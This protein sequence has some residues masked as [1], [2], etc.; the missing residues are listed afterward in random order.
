MCNRFAERHFIYVL[1]VLLLFPA[2]V[3][4]QA[5]AESPMLRN[6][7]PAYIDNIYMSCTG[8]YRP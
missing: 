3:D 1:L 4:I 5:A 7:T 8:R 2:L 6:D